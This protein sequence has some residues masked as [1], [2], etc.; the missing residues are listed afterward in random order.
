[1]TP[2]ESAIVLAVIGVAVLFAMWTGWRHRAIRSSAVVPELYPVP[3]DDEALGAALTAP[4]DAT[5]V[6]T[7]LASDWLDRIAAHGLGARAAAVVRVFDAGVLIERAGAPDLYL[8]AAAVRAVGTASGIAGKVVG[9]E[10]LTALTWQA[11]GAD[12]VELTTGLRVRHAADR[13]LLIE[14]AGALA[15]SSVPPSEPTRAQD[16]GARNEGVQ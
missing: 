14:A 12:G 11:P 13:A 15:G 9:H 2:T 5:Y 3:A 10:G 7:T 4:I 1:V 6:S 16:S 8:P